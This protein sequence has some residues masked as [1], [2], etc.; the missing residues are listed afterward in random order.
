MN[1]EE[2]KN[3]VSKM[4]NVSWVKRIHGG[5]KRQKIHL[6]KLLIV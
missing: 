6:R 2:T 3:I 4:F 5:Q 1:L